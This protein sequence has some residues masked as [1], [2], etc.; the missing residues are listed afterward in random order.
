M[1]PVEET[2]KKFKHHIISKYIH[3]I[4]SAIKPSVFV[5][6]QGQQRHFGGCIS[7]VALIP[8][9]CLESSYRNYQK[10]IHVMEKLVPITL[11]K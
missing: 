2:G 9:K 7:N 10:F 6:E 8:M 5:S 1:K 4:S 3:I 11:M